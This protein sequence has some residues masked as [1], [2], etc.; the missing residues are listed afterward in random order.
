[1]SKQHQRKQPRIDTAMAVHARAYNLV[2]ICHLSAYPHCASRP[3]WTPASPTG[4]RGLGVGGGGACLAVS[5]SSPSLFAFGTAAPHVSSQFLCGAL[6]TRSGRGASG[7]RVLCELVGSAQ[8]SE[9][10]RVLTITDGGNATQVHV[11]GHQVLP[12]SG[13]QQS[14]VLCL[15]GDIVWGR[16]GEGGGVYQPSMP[17][18]GGRSNPR[19]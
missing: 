13:A 2:A 4:S 19:S 6:C 1:M 3:V 7:R 8:D 16:E 14:Q 12:I 10:E 17:D 15:L 9:I 5:P 18:P 11:P